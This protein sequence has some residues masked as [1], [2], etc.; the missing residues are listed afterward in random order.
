M[1]NNILALV[2]QLI[3][4]R[5]SKN[6]SQQKL[7]DLTGMLQPA[8][9]RLESKQVVP[10]LDSICKLLDAMDAELVIRE[11]DGYLK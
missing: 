4:L 5:K 6:L 10:S 9:A 7:A 8:I 11:K 2:D 1:Q 3:A